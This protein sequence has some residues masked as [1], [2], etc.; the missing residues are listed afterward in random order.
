MRI[1]ADHA[2]D[3]QFLRGLSGLDTLLKHLGH[4]ALTCKYLVGC[5][6]HSVRNPNAPHQI[7]RRTRAL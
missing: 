6:L 7:H 4:L 3:E 2:H 1:Q 5:E